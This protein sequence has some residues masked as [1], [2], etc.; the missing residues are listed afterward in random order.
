M[1]SQALEKPDAPPALRWLLVRKRNICLVPTMAS[2]A[3][4]PLGA[5]HAPVQAGG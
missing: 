5:A 1:P 2:L 3:R 4:D